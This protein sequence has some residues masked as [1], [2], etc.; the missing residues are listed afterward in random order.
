MALDQTPGVIVT[1]TRDEV[2]DRYVRDYAL[3]VPEADVGEGTQP[4][5]DGSN[6]ADA[7]APIYA[8]AVT[9]G[10]GTNLATS[11]GEWLLTIGANDDVYPR[12]AV[13][14][15]GFV[16]ITASNGGTNIQQGTELR[17]RIKGTRY[18]IST[19]ALYLSGDSAPVQGLDTGPAT[20]RDAGAIL[21]FTAPPP[22]C[23]QYATVAAQSD[24]SGLTG[25]R[26]AD[27]DRALRQLISDK[28][29]NP[30]ASGNDAQYQ[31]L[32]RI[33]PAI[34]IQQVFTYPA[35]F[36]PGTIAYVFTLNPAGPGRTRVPNAAQIAATEEWVKG[37]LPADDSAFA[38]E[39]AEYPSQVLLRVSWTSGAPTWVDAAPWPPYVA[40]DVVRVASFPTPLLGSFRLYTGTST[41]APQAGQTIGFYDSASGTFK[42]IRIGSVTV[43]TPG[44]A[45]TI[46]PDRTNNA[47]D[48]AFIPT[49]ED[50]ASPWSESLN[51]VAPAVISYFDG[52][53]PGEQAATLPDP[54]MRQRRQPPSPTRWPSVINNRILQPV[55]AVSAVQDAD[56]LFPAVPYQTPTGTR[57]VLSYLLTLER[58]AC[59]Q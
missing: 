20:N 57:G 25:G 19:T 47:S 31:Q 34:S 12:P 41:T 49:A 30:P 2:R 36:G 14:A 48:A 45:W 3:R 16:T 5:V 10:R 44:L 56:V 29:A 35:I 23:G 40:G 4:Y 53:G 43:V 24:G 33:T 55:F 59:Y 52:L 1:S 18:T 21:E 6:A 50:P 13:G 27:D 39:L 37:Q 42:R 9:I 8:D 17:D 26:P 11:A 32:V 54:G 22:G 51:L 28:R 15:S 7:I 46:V 38:C 58:L